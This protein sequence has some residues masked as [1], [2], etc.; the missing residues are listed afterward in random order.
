MRQVRRRAEKLRAVKVN[1]G[2]LG[3]VELEHEVAHPHVAVTDGVEARAEGV[4]RT[5]ELHQKLEDLARNLSQLEH[6][7]L[8]A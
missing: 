5:T 4:A 1:N 6:V 7:L 3:R 8:D 2:A